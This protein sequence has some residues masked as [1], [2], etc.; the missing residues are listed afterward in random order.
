MPRAGVKKVAHLSILMAMGAQIP[1]AG[2]IVTAGRDDTDG[3]TRDQERRLPESISP[4][5]PQ[6]RH[7]SSHTAHSHNQAKSLID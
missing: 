7:S 5:I 3:C 4:D 1:P 2:A 6:F